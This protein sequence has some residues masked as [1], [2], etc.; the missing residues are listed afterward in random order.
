MDL[1][2]T[3]GVKLEIKNRRKLQQSRQCGNGKRR[4][5]QVKGTEARSQK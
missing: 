2:H 3:N 4:D 1:S 5:K